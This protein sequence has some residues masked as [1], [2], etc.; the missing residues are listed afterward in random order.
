MATSFLTVG[1]PYIINITFG[2]SSELYGLI[3]S[4][5]GFGSLA[6]G[7]LVGVFS[8]KLKMSHYHLPLMFVSLAFIPIGI[9]LMIPSNPMLSYWIILF[10]TTAIMG[11]ATMF[12]IIAITFIQ[13]LTPLDLTGKVMALVVAFTTC[14][15]PLG[16]A[17]YGFL[18]ENLTK[19]PYLI[20]FATA[21]LLFCTVFIARKIWRSKSEELL[22][23]KI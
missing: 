19:H 18:F 2:L 6:G 8:V 14:A 13:Q 4:A 21:L 12:S 15:V 9:A 1:I 10:S 17:I 3:Q 5:L 16:Q 23:D 7:I 11:S 22:E 20:A